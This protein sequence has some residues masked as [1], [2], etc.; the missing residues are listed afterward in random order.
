[1][2][3]LWVWDTPIPISLWA[4]EIEKKQDVMLH[5]IIYEAIIQM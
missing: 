1:M 4:I 2:Y 5:I 3:F